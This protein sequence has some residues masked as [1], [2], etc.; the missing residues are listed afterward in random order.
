[1]VFSYLEPVLHKAQLVLGGGLCF[2]FFFLLISEGCGNV[3]HPAQPAGASLT[4]RPCQADLLDSRGG[5]I[6]TQRGAALE[7]FYVLTHR[8]PNCSRAFPRMAA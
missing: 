1:M 7:G 3:W 8:L 6:Q 4:Q 2:G 5:G